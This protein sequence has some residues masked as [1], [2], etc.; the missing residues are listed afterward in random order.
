MESKRE[1]A[2]E[3]CGRRRGSGGFVEVGKSGGNGSA[4]EAAAVERQPARIGMDA[5]IE[6]NEDTEVFGQVGGFADEE[7]EMVDGVGG[8][9]RAGASAGWQR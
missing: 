2:R 8:E 6:K 9:V 7:M 4:A 1:S 5:A 3:A